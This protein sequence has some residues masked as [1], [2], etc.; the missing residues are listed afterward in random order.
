MRIGRTIAAALTGEATNDNIGIPSELRPE[1]PPFDSPNK[2]TA[3]TA[4]R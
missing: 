4:I 3:G 2:I 1:K